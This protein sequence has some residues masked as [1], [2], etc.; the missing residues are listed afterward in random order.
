MFHVPEKYRLTSGHMG[1]NKSA[2]N[3]G[4]FIV[5]SLKLK[6]PLVVQASDG[7]GWEHVSV[8][9]QHRC[10]TW[11]EMCFIKDLFW[12]D[13]D[14]VV[15]MHVPAENYV[16]YHP[17]CLHLWRKLDT[18]DYCEAPHYLLVGPKT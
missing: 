9:L 17:Y 10:P 1:S 12:D 13:S 2:G 3:N 4:M 14:L 15:Q 8:S 5:K 18:N 11:E 6:Q 7:G 16:N